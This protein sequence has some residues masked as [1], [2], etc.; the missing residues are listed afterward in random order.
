METLLHDLRHALRALRHRPGL[1]AAVVATLGIA[2]GAATAVFGAVHGVL[3]QPLPYAAPDRLVMVWQTVPEWRDSDA[4]ILRAFADRFTASVPVYRDWR[5]QT[6]VFETLAAYDPE[7]VSLR[8]GERTLRVRGAATTSNLFD[9]L[10]V[11]PALGRSFAP[12]EAGGERPPVAVLS[13]GLWQRSFGGDSATVGR[14]IVVNGRAHT[15]VGVMPEDFVFPGPATEVWTTLGADALARDRNTQ[16]LSVIGR[17]ASGVEIE[18]ARRAMAALARRLAELYPDG[19]TTGV[20]IVPLVEERVGDVRPV[21]LLL[22][23]G[24]GLLLLVACAN[25]ANLLLSRAIE[26][27]GELGIRAALGAS[28]R[29]LIQ[30]HLMESVLLSLAGGGAGVLAALWLL[31]GIRLAAPAGTPRVDEIAVSGP[32]LGFALLVSLATGVVTGLVSAVRMSNAAPVALQRDAGRGT[33]G[34]PGSSRLQ[35]G[36][37]VAQV[38]AAVGLVVAGGLLGRT[39]L[40]LNAVDLGFAAGRVLAVD[41]TVPETGYQSPAAVLSFQRQALER[42]AAL[43]GVRSAAFVAPLPFGGSW[44]AGSFSIEGREPP[45]GVT[46]NANEGR[47]GPGYFE[48]MGIPVQRGRPFRHADDGDGPPV[49]II[50][51][52]MAERFWPDENPIGSRIRTGG[53]PRTVVG[54]VADVHHG[55]VSERVQPTI[56]IPLAP[57]L[58]EDDDR[59]LSLVVRVAGDP[60]ALAASVRNAID[61]VDPTIPLGRTATLSQLVSES[62]APVR[63]RTVLLSLLAAIAVLL[64]LAGVYAVMSH[65]VAQARVEIGVRLALGATP[66]RVLRSVLARA[67]GIAAA[68]ATIG[69]AGAAAGARVLESYLFG[70]GANDPLTYAAA[71]LGTIAITAGASWSVA[72]RAAGLDPMTVLRRE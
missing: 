19:P 11:P 7:D 70:I 39:M 60:L 31:H 57:S 3:L 38:A 32:V 4:A 68:G 49:A 14:E 51:R 71:A 42:V 21:L 58:M 30:Q 29:R 24:V 12:T 13:H 45:A 67:T 22:L 59:E 64:A 44:S 62:L 55:S 56:Y 53:E 52:T 36:L 63:F 43:P 2:I 72:R 15:V 47:V 5:Q 33:G 28:R 66:G 23:A 20:R 1:T 48:T 10:G 9:L 54:V 8:A 61:E 65:F 27:R 50:N 16:F 25:V 18:R 26:R 34:A 35:R 46:L 17:L 40:Q 6:R 41:L 69:L 37:A